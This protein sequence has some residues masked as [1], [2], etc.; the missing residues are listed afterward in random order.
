M[1]HRDQIE[2]IVLE[3]VRRWGDGYWRGRDG[4]A[5]AWSEVRQQLR[6]LRD[7]ATSL[8]EDERTALQLLRRLQAATRA[9]TAETT[10]D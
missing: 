6:G 9:P 10:G 5:Q 2:A 8:V 1:E 4:F 3:A 7:T